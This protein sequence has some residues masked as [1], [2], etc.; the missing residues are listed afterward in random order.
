MET[1]TNPSSPRKPR[2]TQTIVLIVVA[3]VF[4]LVILCC[5][6]AIAGVLLFQ[7]AYVNEVFGPILPV[8]TPP[9][10]F[11]DAAPSP[12]LSGY[13]GPSGTLD[14]EADPLYGFA[15]L[16]R[17]FSPDPHIVGVGAGGAFDTAQINLA[18][19]FTTEAPAFGFHLYGG[20]SEGF[21]RIYFLPSGATSDSG[22]NIGL[23]VH[24]PDQ[25]WLCAEASSSPGGSA[26]V[27]DFEFAPSGTYTIWV[28]MPQSDVYAPG[29]LYITQ[30]AANT[31]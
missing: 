26:P 24:T 28:G 10:A 5:V 27:V 4:C 21:L 25:Q 16:Q 14:Y 3:V 6:L 15:D 23:V 18:C 12:T 19:G 2:S 22:I 29:M 9:P 13:I 8:V 30:S 31:P 7:P 17:G 1:N 11:P 20:A